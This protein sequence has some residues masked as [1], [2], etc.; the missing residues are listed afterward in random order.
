MKNAPLIAALL[1]AACWLAACNRSS[2][3][4]PVP[5]SQSAAPTASVPAAASAPA[6]GAP[7]PAVSNDKVA[8]KLT[9]LAGNGATNC[10]RPGLNGNLQAAVDCALA[11]AK[12][13]KPFYVAYD[14]P[15]LTVGVAGAAS[16]KLYA[17]QADSP[18]P[19]ASSKV[20]S[21][22]CPATLRVAQ[23]GRVTCVSPGSMG[24][25][26]GGPHTG[27]TMP[28]AG[29]ANPHGGMMMPPA[30]TSNPHPSGSIP[31]EGA[32]SH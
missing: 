32:K 4:S 30:G 7:A 8:Q 25:G 15:G 6:V 28:P 26:G 21:A 18:A 3:P 1:L 14:M 13:K 2:S 5:A 19:G 23:S 12:A 24:I 31:I 29:Q 20:T 10:G 9:E 22:E 27:L 17:V 16:G 11:A